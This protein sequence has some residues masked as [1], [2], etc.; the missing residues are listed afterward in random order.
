M[1]GKNYVIAI[2][3]D[4]SDKNS[5][6]VLGRVEDNIERVGVA[7]EKTGKKL[8]VAFTGAAM[9]MAFGQAIPL[10]KNSIKLYTQM[11]AGLVGLQSVVRYT[12]ADWDLA[13]T[14]LQAYVADGLIPMTDATVTLKNLL[15]RGFNLEESVEVM[16]SFKDFAAFGRQGALSMGEAIRGASE[17]L[18]NMNP[19]LV[20]NVGLT[21]NMSIMY[22]DYAKTIGTT[23]AKLTDAQRI[24]AELM[25]IRQEGAS[26][27]GNALKLMGELGGAMAASEAKTRRLKE[28]IGGALAPAYADLLKKASPVLEMV[29]AFT[30]QN[31]KTVATLLGGAGLV[32]AVA[33][34]AAAFSLM[35]TGGAIVVA[36]TTAVIALGA[37]VAHFKTQLAPTNDEIV[38]AAERH[39]ALGS[40]VEEL[41][42]QYVE[43]AGKPDKSAEEHERLDRV[44][45]ALIEH[46]PEAAQA[47]NDEGRAIDLNLTSL[48]NYIQ[49]KEILRQYYIELLEDRQSEANTRV[50]ETD[51]LLALAL[52]AL[53]E[54]QGEHIQKTKEAV[55]TQ[56][57]FAGAAAD[58]SANIHDMRMQEVY[59]AMSTEDLRL[60]IVGLATDLEDG[61]RAT[62]QIAEQLKNLKGEVDEVDEGI[63]KTED[64]VKKVTKAFVDWNEQLEYFR[65]LYGGLIPMMDEI[66]GEMGEMAQYMQDYWQQ[67]EQAAD[68]AEAAQRSYGDEL[69]RSMSRWGDWVD[70]TVQGLNMTADT[71]STAIGMMVGVVDSGTDSMRQLFDDFFKW[72]WMMIIR[73][74][75]K[76]LIMKAVMSMFGGGGGG[77]TIGEDIIGTVSGFGEARTGG[78]IRGTVPSVDSVWIRGMPGELVASVP[79]TRRLQNLVSDW[80]SGRGPRPALATAEV[81]GFAEAPVEEHYHFHTAD[82]SS[83]DRALRSGRLGRAMD[84][85]RRHGRLRR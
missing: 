17:G 23:A 72:V 14:G 22:K 41:R 46:V 31:P 24:E 21:K 45:E 58:V 67:H 28:A 83:F 52:G 4:A 84:I 30:E 3:V 26:V 6:R 43:L 69:R 70:F 2:L 12:G 9:A 33:A 20:D 80:E 57:D 40:E 50:A 8:S 11:R 56:E 85:A 10:M 42:N 15:L 32:A 74:V 73:T 76:M 60:V 79:L 66:P 25:G 38:T 1:P 65:F 71:M 53:N 48:D 16:K 77:G 37:V 64:G 55:D 13:K 29:I 27:V 75:I 54:K 44:M 39:E 62:K 47:F 59:A 63:V 78:M 51:R 18:K 5:K 61:D 82:F 36:I 81:G 34:L 7:G 35:G 49:A 68:A 19:M